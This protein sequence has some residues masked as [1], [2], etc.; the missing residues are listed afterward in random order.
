MPLQSNQFLVTPSY[1]IVLHEDVVVLLLFLVLMVVCLG[2]F[3]S[4][5]S[6]V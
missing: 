6:R 5:M 2:S 3:M 1:S 4:R